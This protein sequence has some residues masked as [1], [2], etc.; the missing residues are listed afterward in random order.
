MRPALLQRQPAEV[1]AVVPEKVKSEQA[2]IS[3]AFLAS[4]TMDVRQPVRQST[5]HE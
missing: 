2:S 4:E 5:Q 1:S 3:A